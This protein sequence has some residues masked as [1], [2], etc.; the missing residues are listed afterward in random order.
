MGRRALVALCL[1]IALGAGLRLNRALDPIDDPGADAVRYGQLART[2]YESGGYRAEDTRWSPGAPLLYSGA[3]FVTFGERPLVA[4]LLVALLGAATILVVY[5]L[6]RRMAGPNAGLL[7][8][9][10]A[11]IYP[12][13]VYDAGRLMSEPPAELWLSSAVL[14]FIW[15]T[16]RRSAWAWALPGLLLGL[17][18]LTR[19]EYL[20]FGPLFAVLAAIRAW[21]PVPGPGE[22]M[23]GRRR[24]RRRAHGARA[25]GAANPSNGDGYRWPRLVLAAVLLAAFALPILPWT[26]RNAIVL[27]RFVPVT[28]LAGEALY[29]GTYLPG[30]GEHFGVKRALYRQ[31]H[32]HTKLSDGEIN[33]VDFNPLL[34][35]VASRHPDEPRDVA[36]GRIGRQNLG[37]FLSDRPLDYLEMTSAKVRHM[38]AGSGR[39]LRGGVGEVF[40]Y[41]LLALAAVGLGEL[42]RRRRLEAALIGVLIGGVTLTAALLLAST[43]RNLPLMPL[44]IVLASVGA[45]WLVAFTRERIGRLSSS[46]DAP[47]SG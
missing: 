30:G 39:S 2:L 31:F 13:F 25:V 16:E 24:M 34:D 18:A 29:I 46:G 44:L 3:Y 45:T 35:R 23:S 9:A 33:G 36:L 38:W 10:A 42:V 19:P 21:T 4:R 26:V 41:A 47:A 5:L 1:I 22:L 40:H 43:R 8:A 20:L 11:A 27:D 15:A 28:T 6:A 17:T 14:A 12:A 7:A 32:P 37:D